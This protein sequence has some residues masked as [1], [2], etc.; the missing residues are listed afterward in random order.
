MG[1]R[2]P[3]LRLDLV[4]RVRERQQKSQFVTY[5]S[6]T[7]I[8]WNAG[9]ASSLHPYLAGLSE[10]AEADTARALR[11]FQQSNRRPALS[12]GQV[13]FQRRYRLM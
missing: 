10:E 11:P 2:E 5:V 6:T 9:T 4:V 8:P 12:G 1:R 3:V 13:T 7:T